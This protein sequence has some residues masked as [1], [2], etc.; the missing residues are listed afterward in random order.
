ML[1]HQAQ[2]SQVVAAGP[3]SRKSLGGGCRPPPS[4]QLEPAVALDLDSMFG[5]EPPSSSPR[6]ELPAEVMKTGQWCERN[7]VALLEA[8]CNRDVGKAARILGQ[9]S[10]EHVGEERMKNMV[11]LKDDFRDTAL[12][13]SACQGEVGIVKLLLARGADV[14]AQNNLGSTPL[15]RAAVAGRTEVVELL[16]D[17]GANLEH[18]DDISG[19]S[20]HGA[21]RRNHCSTVRLL[22]N[23]GASVDAADGVGNRPL[24]LASAE[25]AISALG[26]LV[27]HYAD[28]QV[29]NIRGQTPLDVAQASWIGNSCKKKIARL[30]STEST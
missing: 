3:A 7:S 2:Q 13:L 17:A 22:L 10:A 5:E 19:T 21:A 11:M 26:V 6:D 1:V 30:L 28:P 25:G 18:Q 8:C 9:A 24:H 20:L 27:N 23:R 16:L 12:H 4:L 14:H 15:N 29:K